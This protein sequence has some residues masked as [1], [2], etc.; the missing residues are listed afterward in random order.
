MTTFSA[1]PS[2]DEPTEARRSQ[3]TRDEL[4]FDVIE[5]GPP[6]GEPVVLL[7]GFPQFSGSW[8]ALV[9][10]LTQQ[11]YRTLMM[12]QR[13][14]SVGARPRGRWT[15]RMSELVADVV[16]LIDARGGGPVHLVGHDWGA[17]VAWALTAR[18]PEKVCSLTALSVPHP[19]GFITAMATSA[20]GLKSWYMYFFQLPW[21]PERL[22]HAQGV[23]FLTM[24]GQS[25][26]R[27]R[28]DAARFPDPA[29]LTGPLNW[30]RAM[31]FI[32]PR[33]AMKPVRRPTLFV[34]SDGD[35]AIS[36]QAAETCERYVD[37]PYQFET[38]RGVNHWIP[39]AATS[40]LAALL[41]PHLQR[42]SAGSSTAP[43]R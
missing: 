13:G 36:R 17:A 29:A 4:R 42:W 18:R 39:E 25:P 27:A 15:Y 35:S 7:H 40:E 2:A 22:L 38:L 11:G 23:R 31:T 28:R 6:D 24:F 14:Y 5:V 3:L 20:Q 1:E 32:D 30:Y 12:D 10:L 16:A 33:A 43:S 41:I 8:D 37:A 19:W 34:W 26:E 21:L 9:A